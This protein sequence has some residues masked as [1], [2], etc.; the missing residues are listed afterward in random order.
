MISR[1]SDISDFLT[2]I[3]ESNGFT[4]I[5]SKNNYSEHTTQ[6]RFD[7]GANHEWTALLSSNLSMIENIYNIEKW[8]WDHRADINKELKNCLFHVPEIRFSPTFET[9]RIHYKGRGKHGEDSNRPTCPHC[10]QDLKRS[11]E[12]IKQG[13]KW[14]KVPYGYHCLKCKY[15]IFD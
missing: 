9:K 5:D 15:Q 3:K 8:I 7:S 13:V 11:Y 2:K 10:Q 1:K 14:I 12:S 6:L 4:F